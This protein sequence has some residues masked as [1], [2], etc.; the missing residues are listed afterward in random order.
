M[1]KTLLVC[2]VVLLSGLSLMAQEIKRTSSVKEEEVPV[3]VRKAFV[4]DLGAIP[5]EGNWKV[6]FTVLNDGAKTVAKPLWYTFS[7]KSQDDK[8]EVRY[9]PEGKLESFKGINK[10]NENAATINKTDKSS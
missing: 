8:I 5:A 7:K 2:S 10:V 1:K 9:T 6:T 3:A 4:D